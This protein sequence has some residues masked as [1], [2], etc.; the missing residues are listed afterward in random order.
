M[1]RFYGVSESAI[2]RSLA[3]AGGDGDGVEVTICAR[4]FELHVDLFVEEGG[5]AR[6]TTIERQLLADAGRYLFAQRE[7]ANGGARTRA[8]ARAWAHTRDGRV[9][10]RRPRRGAADRRAGVERRLRRRRDRRTRTPA[11]ESQLGVPAELLAAHGA[12]SAEVAAAMAHGARERLGADVAVAVTGVAGPGGGTAEKPVGLVFVHASGPLGE[13]ELRLDFPGDRETI[14]GRATVA[15]LHLVR[16]LLRSRDRHVT[17]GRLAWRAVTGS[18]SSAPS[19]LPDDAVAGSGGLAGR[20]RPGRTAG[21]RRGNLHVTLAFLGARPNGEVPAIAHELARGG[22]R[23]RR[24]CGSPSGATA[25]RTSVGMLVFDDV[26]GAA[27][28]PRGRARSAARA[29]WRLPPRAA[30]VA[31][32]RHRLALPGAAAARPTAALASASSVPSGAALYSSSLRPSGAH[33]DVL[34]TVALG[35]R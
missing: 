8:A 33:Y 35:G 29:G 1:L 27:S 32:A 20:A 3:A 6:A 30:P 17:R 2:A 5:D 15:A 28:A 13:R 19:Q 22:G 10:H 31:A 23:E 14:R 26:D 21:A 12:V 7:V 16:R 9:V 24:R 34:E 4:D 18:A 25:R 11:K